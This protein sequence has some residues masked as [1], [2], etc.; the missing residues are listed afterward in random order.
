MP[1]EVRIKGFLLVILFL[2][3]LF[4]FDLVILVEVVG[5]SDYR[6]GSYVNTVYHYLAPFWQA[7]FWTVIRLPFSDTV[8][9]V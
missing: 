4:F 3:L 8:A 2:I 1:T 5:N 9:R 6:K 7:H